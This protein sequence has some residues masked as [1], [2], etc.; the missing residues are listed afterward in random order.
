RGGLPD[1]F[2][3]LALRE[4]E[5][6]NV[7]STG[8]DEASTGGCRTG[9]ADFYRQL[10]AWFVDSRNGEVRRRSV[11]RLGTSG[12]SQHGRES[13][14]LRQR[15]ARKQEGRIVRVRIT[16]KAIPLTGVVPGTARPIL[17]RRTADAAVFER[18]ELMNGDRYRARQM[19][20]PVR[21]AY[22]VLQVV[23]TN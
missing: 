17:A 6:E 19:I 16:T 12:R 1:H 23:H 3:D 2:Y 13:I 7:P 22:R 10:S 11:Q 14:I 21:S 9:V 15:C 4:R 20:R 5:V 8:F 18:V